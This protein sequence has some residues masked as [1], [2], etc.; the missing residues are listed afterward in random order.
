MLQYT[1]ETPKFFPLSWVGG[2]VSNIPIFHSFVFTLSVE[3]G[4]GN[5]N[6]T[7]FKGNSKVSKHNKEGAV[8]Q[9]PMD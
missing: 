4:R 1:L 8:I 3:E 9:P 2:G 7:N 5:V 6:D